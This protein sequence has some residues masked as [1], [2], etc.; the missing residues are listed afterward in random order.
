MNIDNKKVLDQYQYK[1]YKGR[2][3]K[4]NLLEEKKS[5]FFRGPRRKEVEGNEAA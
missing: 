2:R 4:T 5:I 3:P 1:K